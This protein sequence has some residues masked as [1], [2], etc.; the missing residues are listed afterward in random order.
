MVFKTRGVQANR[1]EFKH[2]VDSQHALAIRDFIRS[3]LV[4][5]PH[6]SR[7]QME[8]YPVKSVYL[9]SSNFALCHAT[10]DGIKNRFKLRLRYY[11]Y[12]P[13][14][15]VFFEV[16]RRVDQTILK[17]RAAVKREHI[18]DIFL[19]R[20]FD[21]QMLYYPDRIADLAAIQSFLILRD[22]MAARPNVMNKYDREAYVSECDNSVRVTF[23]RHLQGGNW[24]GDLEHPQ[25]ER[26]LSPK[27]GG[28]IL[29]LKF[30]QRFPT[31]MHELSRRFQLQ[32]TSVPKYVECA[33][34]LHLGKSP[35]TGRT[36]DLANF[37]GS[38]IA[39]K[40]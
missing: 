12:H 19:G 35:R 13:D 11:D 40:F 33:K 29:E 4:L 28:V 21:R 24:N 23:D 22:K 25:G 39:E 9:D 18:N 14:R 1:F 15:P 30:T 20:G 7:E 31:W 26:W 38:M 34:Q 5:D 16:K 37:D 36:G 10:M 17:S 6:M 2:L 27:I 8:G 32:K 3:H